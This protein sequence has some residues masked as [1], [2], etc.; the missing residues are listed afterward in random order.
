MKIQR[1]KIIT[2]DINWSEN[3]LNQYYKLK[4]DLFE[5]EDSLKIVL[6]EYLLLNPNIQDDPSTEL[7]PDEIRVISFT[8][9]PNHKYTR[10]EIRYFPEDPAGDFD[11][12]FEASISVRQFND[13]LNFMNDPE[14]YKN[15]KKYNLL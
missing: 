5:M 4:D 7:Y 11:D 12:E 2:E 6:A 14:N 9:Q 15:A 3:K 1:F 8:Y 10:F 13:F